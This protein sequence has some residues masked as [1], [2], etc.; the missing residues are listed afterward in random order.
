MQPCGI[1]GVMSGTSLDGLDLA[2]CEFS[3]AD[4]R[5]NWQIKAAETL[6]YDDA[7]KHKLGHLPQQTAYEATLT[8]TEYGTYIGQA[9]AQFIK[10][11]GCTASYISSHGHTVFHQPDKRLTWQAGHGAYIAAAAGLTVVCDFRSTDVALGGQGAPLVPVGDA[12]LFSSYDACLNLG[13]FANISF[14]QQGKRIAYDICALNTVLNHL[15]EKLGMEYDANG[16]MAESGSIHTPLLDKLNA[17]NYYTLKAPK[18]LGMEWVQ[19]CIFPMLNESG[20]LPQDAMA[21][22]VRHAAQQITQSINAG[23][24]VLITGG[25]A[26]HTFLLNELKQH[27]MNYVLP[28]REVIEFKEALIFAFL[29]YLRLH[30]KQ[31]VWSSVTG[32][33][34]DSISGC[35]Y[36]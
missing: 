25:G 21:T 16:K 7:W 12:L 14:G 26:Y 2:W 3:F 11:Y 20:L 5:W 8:H 32:A 33:T 31:N 23:E 28:E 9:V 27:G 15:A 36:L 6:P 30:E 10:K 35:V 22:Y 19:A 1:I 18:S 24:K 17:L 4:N 29:G 34:A 13:G